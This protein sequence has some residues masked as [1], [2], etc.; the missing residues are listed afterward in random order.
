MK[1]EHLIS[2]MNFPGLELIENM[3]IREDCLVINQVD[4]QEDVGQSS[5][6]FHNATVRIYSFLEKGISLSREN[7]LIRSHGDLLLFS[8][9]DMRYIDNYSSIIINE[10]ENNPHADVIVFD[11]TRENSNGRWIAPRHGAEKPLSR[12]R[13]WDALQ[14]GTTNIVVKRR[15]LLRHNIHFD[16]AFGNGI[17]GSEDTLF[18]FDALKSGM[19]IYRSPIT[20]AS[21]DVG[22]SSWFSGYD[23]QYLLKAGAMFYRLSARLYPQISLYYAIKHRHHF[24]GMGI[25]DILQGLN[26]GKKDYIHRYGR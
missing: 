21:T 24:E 16:Q 12:I 10:F 1:V 17:Y 14:Y 3:V 22:S 4:H 23:L 19:K 5:L 6:P 18:I 20:I 7:A 9:D 2:T 11:V 15:S 8:D 25:R 26:Q 13:I